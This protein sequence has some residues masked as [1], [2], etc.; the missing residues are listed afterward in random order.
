MV[1]EAVR[2]VLNG[3]GAHVVEQLA[4]AE[5]PL[6]EDAL[7]QP[8]LGHLD[9]VEPAL[10][11]RGGEHEG[12]A[13]DHVGAVVLDAL[14]L[15][16]LRRRPL[17]QLLDQL[18]ERLA[19]ELEPLHV[20]VRDV[21]PLHR[22][23]GEVADRSADAHEPP[24]AA[25]PAE[26][27]EL[28][29][30]VG[31]QRLHLLHA[32]LLLRAGSARSPAPHPAAATA[33][34]RAAGPRSSSP[35]CCR[36]R[37]RG[38]TRPRSSWSWPARASRNAPPR[39][40]LITRASSPV[41][42]LISASSSAPFLASR[43]ALVATATTS[44]TPVASQKAENTAAVWRARSTRSARSTP[45]SPIPA[46]I[47]TASRISSTRLHQGVSGMYPNTTRRQELDPMSMTAT[48]STGEMMH[49][50]LNFG[51]ARADAVRD[52]RH[53]TGICRF[54][55]RSQARQPPRSCGDCG[56]R[57]RACR[58]RRDP[59]CRRCAFGRC[60]RDPRR[61]RRS[62]SRLGALLPLR[63]GV[64]RRADRGQEADE[65][66]CC[67]RRRPSGRDARD[68]GSHR[69]ARRRRHRCLHRGSDRDAGHGR[70]PPAPR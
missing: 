28:A 64:R 67:S 33:T 13:E 52:E 60:R 3:L 41:L 39:S 55:Q 50:S 69:S 36:R 68:R 51:R 59:V 49:L 15:R 26:L 16:S 43:I 37:C 29:G 48:R 40:P 2:E 25:P 21:E 53:R 19:R 57:N 47:R 32:R 65:A 10:V 54:H 11:E 31:A 30:N 1:L 61:A 5:Q 58:L 62:D 35:G 12:A 63:H 22:R 45:S 46:P 18:L 20:D 56:P 24:A 34:P 8:G 17:G 23:G 9:R 42:R 38:R 27:F 66:P 14:H 44:S 4:L 6:E 7:A 70:A